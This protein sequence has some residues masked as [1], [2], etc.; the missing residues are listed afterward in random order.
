MIET[1]AALIPAIA[2]ILTALIVTQLRRTK[3]EH[4]KKEKERQRQIIT[5]TGQALGMLKEPWES[6]AKLSQESIARLVVEQMRARF[7]EVPGISKEQI[8][9]EIENKLADIQGRISKLEYQF[10]DDAQSEKI[11]KIINDLTILSGEV[12]LLTK[13]FESLERKI[14]TRWDVAVIVSIII[15]GIFSVVAA[16]YGVIN[17]ITGQ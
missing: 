1:L 5:E 2:S 7:A 6:P 11:A 15:A 16:T 12:K 13:Q 10:P 14:L 8:K 9:K 3:K 17:F 4:L